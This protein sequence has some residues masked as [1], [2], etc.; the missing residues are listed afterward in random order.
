MAFG[1]GKT[2]L[3]F[4][5]Q[6]LSVDVSILIY[7]WENFKMKVLLP[8]VAV[9]VSSMAFAM[10]SL[11]IWSDLDADTYTYS[12]SWLGGDLTISSVAAED[13]QLTLRVKMT[14]AGS[15]PEG[16]SEYFVTTVEPGATLPES[17]ALTKTD[18]EWTPDRRQNPSRNGQISINVGDREVLSGVLQTY[19]FSTEAE[20]IEAADRLDL[21]TDADELS[22]EYVGAWLGGILTIDSITT[23]E[24]TVQLR[25]KMT[26]AG[27]IPEGQ[28]E[29]FVTDLT[30]GSALPLSADLTKTDAEWT[31]DRRQNPARNGQIAID[32]GDRASL[33]GVLQG[34]SFSNTAT[35]IEE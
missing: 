15:I 12:G 34:F 8:A 13:D 26:G 24:E 23:E 10:T 4:C 16:R 22:Y 21:W 28:S 1:I 25:V 9:A 32:L 11:D 5:R 27:S 31:P 6:W 33:E 35:L 20:L 19:R 29:Y 3:K 7:I 2:E 18:D 14:G 17:F 30:P